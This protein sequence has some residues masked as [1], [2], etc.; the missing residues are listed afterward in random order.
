[1]N[2]II[3]EDPSG[4]VCKQNC[5][6]FFPNLREHSSTCNFDILSAEAYIQGPSTDLPQNVHYNTS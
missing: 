5:T 3:Q 6:I 1:M 2:K 4:K